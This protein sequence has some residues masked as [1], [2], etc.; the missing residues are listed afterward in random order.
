MYVKL[1]KKG[2]HT[3]NMLLLKGGPSKSVDIFIMRSIMADVSRCLSNKSIKF[4]LSETF[5][6]ALRQLNW[7]VYQSYIFEIQ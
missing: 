2:I 6:S 4:P 1:K 3:V 5:S 7:Y